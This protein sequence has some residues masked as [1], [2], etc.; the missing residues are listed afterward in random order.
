MLSERERL[1]VAS[2]RPTLKTGPGGVF[3]QAKRTGKRPAFR[4]Q[5]LRPLVEGGLLFWVNRCRTA[6]ALTDEGER[7]L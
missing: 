2:A 6:A 5:E 1:I 3:R 4:R 7:S